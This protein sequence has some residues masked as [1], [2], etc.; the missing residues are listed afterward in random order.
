MAAAL[1]SLLAGHDGPVVALCTGIPEDRSVVPPGVS[2]VST[3]G[4][5]LIVLR[6]V[7]ERLTADASGG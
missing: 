5:N 1:R 2:V 7:A 6:A 3:G 4:R